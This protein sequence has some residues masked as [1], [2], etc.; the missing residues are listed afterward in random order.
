MLKTIRS[1]IIVMIVAFLVVLLAMVYVHLQNGFSTIAKSNSTS[2]LQKLNAMLFEGL[3][4]A[5]N[6]G[7]PEVIN[8][9]IEGSKHVEGIAGL[10]IFPAD[11]VIELMGMENPHKSDEAEV[12]EVFANKTQSLRPYTQAQD[13]GYIMI[14]PILAL[15][16]CLDCHVNVKEGD[17][18][19]VAKIQIS[20][21]TLMQYLESVQFDIVLWVVGLGFIALLG[22]LFFFNRFVFYPI[23]NLTQVAKD[24]SQGDGDLTKRL[25]IKNNDEIAKASGYINDFISKISNTIASTKSSSHQNID[26][27]NKLANASEEINTRIEKSVEVVH[28]SAELG[29]NIELILNN[30]IDLV[31]QSATEVRESSKQLLHTRDMLSKMVQSLQENISAEHEIAQHLAQSAQET[32]RIKDVLT[33]IADIADQ[34]SLLALNANIEAARAGESGRGFAVVADEVRKLAERTQKGLSEINVVVNA[35]VQ[36]ISDANIAMSENVEN[37]SSMTDVSK[38]S[39]EVLEHSVQSLKDAVQASALSLQKT[40]ELFDAVKAILTQVSEVE[41]LTNQNSQSVRTINNI[42][43]DIATKAKE[44]NS[45]LDSFKC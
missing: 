10:A 42:S 3:K 39:T 34:T 43:H 6:T 4:I 21:K 30:S 31:Q 28:T 29:K 27:A 25:P 26:Q 17:V 22:L 20:N 40:N 9:F 2:E 11:S 18:L 44:L 32:T 1:K 19:G 37:I 8:T 16:S 23:N 5:M 7:D 36:S 33:I 38:E 35:V 15:E 24:L 14:K 13:S 12:L 41:S 45:Q